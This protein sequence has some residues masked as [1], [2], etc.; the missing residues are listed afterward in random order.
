MVKCGNVQL[1]SIQYP[2][3]KWE[4]CQC[5]NV[6]NSNFQLSIGNIGIGNWQHFH[7]GNIHIDHW[8]HWY[9]QHFHIGNISIAT[10]R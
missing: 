5:E 7:I 10:N 3:S 4:C 9:W 8:Q 1:S 6:A 2:V